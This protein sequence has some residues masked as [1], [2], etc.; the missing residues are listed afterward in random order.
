MRLVYLILGWLFVALA[1]A[2]VVLPVL[3]T[4]PFLI[5]AVGCF[6]RSSP[7][8]EA[9]LL[10]H[11]RFGPVLR[12][13]RS[14]GAIPLRAKLFAYSGMTAGY[15]FFWVMVRPGWPLAAA[16]AA[17]MAGGAAYVATRPLPPSP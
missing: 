11:P 9:W 2:G 16:V 1:F 14:H 6:A 8:L 3:P 13:W 10:A 7:R 17:L 15:V 4:T 12:D 5:V